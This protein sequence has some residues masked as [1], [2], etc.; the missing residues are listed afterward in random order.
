M[1]SSIVQPLSAVAGTCPDSADT[2]L[3]RQRLFFVDELPPGTAERLACLY[4]SLFSVPEYFEV[5]DDVRPNMVLELREPD[6]LLA[7]TRHDH[8]VEVLNK[9][10]DIDAEA[11]SRSVET[12]FADLPDIRR[13][14]L[15]VKFTPP[16]RLDRD[17]E[18]DGG[19]RSL[20]TRPV[21][22]LHAGADHVIDHPD[23]S[24][25]YL[26]GLGSST[27]RN[28]AKY[29]N[30]LDRRAVLGIDRT[31]IFGPQIGD[32]WFDRIV[33]WNSER[34][35]AKGQDPYYVAHPQVVAQLKQLA[36]TYGVLDRVEVDGETAS[37]YLSFYVGHDAWIYLG[38]FDR[39]FEREHLGLLGLHWAI[40]AAADRGMR[41]THL[42]WGDALYKQRLG[43]VPV[44]AY[45]IAVY[46]SRID[47]LIGRPAWRDLRAAWRLR[48]ADWKLPARLA[49]AVRRRL[50]GVR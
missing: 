34:I 40:A 28:L 42:L 44:T 22:L 43:A 13:L 48:L 11:V 2:A 21:R 37:A 3:S 14:A 10:I 31:A 35:S 25:A 1:E 32:E 23:G 9:V 5:V 50:P 33:R 30:R 47:S 26:D 19:V 38:S 49:Y 18:P 45:R 24:R 12:L 39:S 20:T 29:A 41:R 7:L 15:E 16:R 6:H 8:S 46:R 27:R 17:V 4:G 36:A